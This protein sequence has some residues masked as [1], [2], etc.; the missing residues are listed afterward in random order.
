MTRVPSKLLGT[1]AEIHPEVTEN[2]SGFKINKI[3]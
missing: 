3:R 1:L 2:Q